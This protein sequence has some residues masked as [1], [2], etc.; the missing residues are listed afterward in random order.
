MTEETAQ[1]AAQ[2]GR[3]WWRA[4]LPIAVTGTVTAL[5]LIV[6][7]VASPHA[8]ASGDQP[9]APSPAPAALRECDSGSWFDARFRGSRVLTL[10][11]ALS[12]LS[13]QSQTLSY[14]V[15]MKRFAPAQAA[16]VVLALARHGL[17][18]GRATVMCNTTTCLQRFTAT[19]AARIGY[20]F[21]TL[22]GWDTD[23]PVLVPYDVPLDAGLVGAAQRRGSLVMSVQGH[24]GSVRELI[25]LGFDGVLADDLDAA[26]AERP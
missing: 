25:R 18:D 4:T 17:D 26:L 14:Y 20:V 7:L 15:H 1:D 12:Q 9:P 21:N 2:P 3:P 11:E 22:D 6:S 13:E 8:G 5:V 16:A 24:P 23:W 19:G 10:D